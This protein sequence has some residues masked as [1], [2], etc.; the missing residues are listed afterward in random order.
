MALQLRATA[1]LLALVVV[2]AL[3]ISGGEAKADWVRGAMYNS[4]WQA[5]KIQC[6]QWPA[7]FVYSGQVHTQDKMENVDTYYGSTPMLH[8]V[9]VTFRL[10]DNFTG[11]DWSMGYDPSVIDNGS[12]RSYM[13]PWPYLSPGYSLAPCSFIG[14]PSSIP[15][16]CN[17]GRPD[18]LANWG[19]NAQLVY[20]IAFTDGWL[21]TGGSLSFQYSWWY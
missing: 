9:R 11:A 10:I 14:P 6:I 20:S 13:S 5:S 19:S 17:W 2:F 1:L 8:D 16:Y 4:T 12:M 7:C 21:N 18:W 15:R 3:L